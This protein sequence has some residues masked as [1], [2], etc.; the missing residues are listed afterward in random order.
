MASASSR[1]IGWPPRRRNATAAV[2]VMSR[3]R[4]MTTAS[5]SS[6]IKRRRRRGEAVQVFGRRCAQLTGKP[7][8]GR[9]KGTTG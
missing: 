8:R 2:F 6:S 7:S 9:A 1:V 5:A 4:R 3:Y